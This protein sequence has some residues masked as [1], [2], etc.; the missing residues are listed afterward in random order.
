MSLRSIQSTLEK[1]FN[2]K[3]AISLICKWIKTFCKI[4]SIDKNKEDK[5]IEEKNKEKKIIEILEMD[6]LY[7]KY[8][9]VKK[10]N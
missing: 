7:S 8:Y 3:I 9:D 6:E 10:T 2:I 4:L 1:F 5:E